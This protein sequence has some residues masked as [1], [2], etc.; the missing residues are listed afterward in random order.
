MTPTIALR[1]A[2]SLLF[3]PSAWTQG[4]WARD[5]FGEPVPACDETARC[6]CAE[7][8]LYRVCAGDTALC[9][10]AIEALKNTLHRR[11]V[12]RW[13]DDRANRRVDVVAALRKAAADLERRT[14]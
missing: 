2:A 6:W 12:K 4:A 7:G 10:A 11:N 1:R 14:Q 8:A 3:N 13:N 5:R 9:V